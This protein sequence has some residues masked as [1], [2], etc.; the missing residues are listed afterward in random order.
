M[1]HAPEGLPDTRALARRLGLSRWAVSRALN[2]QPGVSAETRA[3]VRG[4]AA[5]AGFEPNVHARGL[6]GAG[7]E[8]TLLAV[9]NL[10]DS[11]WTS[12]ASGLCE[13]L[14]IRGV[15]PDWALLGSGEPGAEDRAWARAVARRATALLVLGAVSPPTMPDAGSHPA[16]SELGRRGVPVIFVEPTWVE[17][18]DGLTVVRS[19]HRAAAALVASHLQA[20]GHRRVG[21]RGFGARERA[22]AAALHAAC[23]AR[24]LSCEEESS[25][26]PSPRPGSSRRRGRPAAPTAAPTAVV[27][28]DDLTALRVMCELRARGLKV[29]ADCSLVGHGDEPAG[30]LCAPALTTVDPQRPQLVA[31]TLELFDEL[32]R[33]PG[34][35][36][37][38]PLWVAPLLRCRGSVANVATTPVPA[39]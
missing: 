39:G 34:G 7:P 4:A 38:G 21:L 26:S 3:R 10:R 11:P 5:A 25:S 17:E 14:I 35:V 23:G 37:A 31:R 28:A 15:Q 18:P 29:P 2:D 8:L 36:Q 24:G 9:P 22:R 20:A 30:F 6:R 33:D 19:D 13:G 1:E 32:R 16:W 27:T 12:L